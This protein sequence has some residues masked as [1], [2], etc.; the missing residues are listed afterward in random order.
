[1]HK[2]NEQNF[3]V[4]SSLGVTVV[5][6]S[7]DR[8]NVLESDGVVVITLIASPPPGDTIVSVLFSTQDGSATGEL[9]IRSGISY[10]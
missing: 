1:M 4:I 5:E 6:F 8:Y 10:I 3:N 7:A 2:Q 9:H